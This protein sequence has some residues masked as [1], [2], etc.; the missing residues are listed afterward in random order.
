MFR[1]VNAQSF[2]L[3]AVASAPW[4]ITPFVLGRRMG[5]TPSLDEESA[6][7]SRD[8]PIPRVSVVLPA[9]NEAAHIDACMR[10][11]VASNW[12]N[13]E[14]IVVDDHS[15]DCTGD[16]ARRIAA[17]HECV[18][19]VSAPALP[20]GW[21]GKQ[22]ACQ[23]GASHATGS[24]LLFTDADTRHAPDL[25]TRLIATKV[26]RGA[27]LISVAGRQDMLTIWERAV[28]PAVFVL[29]LMR[30]GGADTLEQA[31]RATDVIANG[32][33]FMVSRE[34][35]DAIGQHA[36]VKSFV[37]EDL[38]IAQAMWRSGRR[39]SLVRGVSQLSTRMYDGL[40]PLMRGWG[41]N[42]YAG[43]RFSIPGG[44]IGRALFPILLP[45]FPLTLLMPFVV[46]VVAVFGFA[47]SSISSDVLLAWSAL[48]S[49]GVLG[50]FAVANK[51]NGD[52][53]RRGLLAPLGAAVL[54]AICI[55]AVLRGNRVS[56]K[57]RE[58]VA[59]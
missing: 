18:T 11:I 46:F 56:W 50:T 15:T 33:C 17:S 42:V 36:A 44:T 48:A 39:V 12:P 6:T 23:T 59:A 3:A 32:Q 16:I 2:L 51:L 13:V 54:L 41:K 20:P 37:A 52:P 53:M 55:L 14:L 24:L 5:A 10:S 8:T 4:W 58:Y 40:A 35:Y 47:T 22:W 34:A 38:M 26:R 19:I 45:L 7:P 21:F 43:G 29:I 27:E 28:Q 9:R 57:D 1:H 49:A 30:Y 25:I 31:Q